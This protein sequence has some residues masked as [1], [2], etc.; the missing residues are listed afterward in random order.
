MA[1][2]VDQSRNEIDWDHAVVRFLELEGKL[3]SE[4]PAAIEEAEDLAANL[5]DPRT[6]NADAVWA[7]AW[8]KPLYAHTKVKIA[9]R[10]VEKL[11]PCVDGAWLRWGIKG[12]DQFYISK[13]GKGVD[14]TAFETTPL[15]QSVRQKTGIAWYR[16]FAI[17]GAAGALRARD[18][19]S[20]TPYADLVGVDPGVTVPLVRSEMGPFWGYITVLHFFTDLG[21][22]C[23]PDVHLTKTVHCLGMI[24]DLKTKE[25]PSL[26][27]AITINRHVRCLVEKLEGCVLP[28][29]MRHFDKVQRMRYVDKVLMEISKNKLI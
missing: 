4:F 14:E 29:R 20:K 28:E 11:R 21:L 26:T 13:I 25:P 6:A 23:K 19:R 9:D 3:A 15:A 22:G 5:T 24:T 8:N 27:D 18:L 16:L 2:A 10:M 1:L 17:Q 12:G 7:R